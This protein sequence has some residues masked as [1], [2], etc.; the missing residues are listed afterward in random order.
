MNTRQSKVKPIVVEVAIRNAIARRLRDHGIAQYDAVADEVITDLFA[1][2]LTPTPEGVPTQ[3]M[4]QGMHLNW[5][6]GVDTRPVTPIEVL[7]Y[8]QCLRMKWDDGLKPDEVVTPVRVDE[9]FTARHLRTMYTTLWNRVKNH[10]APVDSP[11]EYVLAKDLL[12]TDG[13]HMAYAFEHLEKFGATQTRHD[14]APCLIAGV[15]TNPDPDRSGLPKPTPRKAKAKASKVKVEPV[16][17]D[18]PLTQHEQDIADI[19]AM[20]ADL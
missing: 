1:T 18:V 19:E 20:L 2:R 6:Q 5:P 11:P 13:T 9:D 15:C 17:A 14:P 3:F 4:Y 16:V 8:N 10:K 12:P 7:E